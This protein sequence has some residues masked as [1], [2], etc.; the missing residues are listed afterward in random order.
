MIGAS[1]LRRPESP[2]SQNSHSDGD[3]GS[4]VPQSVFW[5]QG[6]RRGMETCLWAT[7]QQ[8][9]KEEPWKQTK[10]QQLGNKG[11]IRKRR[12]RDIV[13]WV[14]RRKPLT[15]LRSTESHQERA[16]N[17]TPDFIA[18][19]L[20]RFRDTWG[21]MTKA[22]HELRMRKWRTEVRIAFSRRLEVKGI[23]YGRKRAEG[24]TVR[25]SCLRTKAK[26]CAFAA[27]HGNQR[28]A[29]ASWHPSKPRD[30]GSA[31]TWFVQWKPFNLSLRLGLPSVLLLLCKTLLFG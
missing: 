24:Q 15:L 27:A 7:K 31:P 11:T 4:Q 30:V 21:T 10:Q 16:G 1:D 22:P 9:E 13:S 17:W 18:N 19:S 2:G 23:H 8:A 20:G 6:R 25:D 3:W 28:E 12:H 5:P 26:T 29:C 14:F